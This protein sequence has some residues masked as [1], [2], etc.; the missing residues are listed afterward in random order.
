MQ[1]PEGFEHLHRAG[2]NGDVDQAVFKTVAARQEPPRSQH[3]P[4]EDGG[5]QKLI[6]AGDAFANAQPCQAHNECKQPDERERKKEKTEHYSFSS[7]KTLTSTR[8]FFLF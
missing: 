5:D 7:G 2:Q 1:R 3:Q 6:P 8:R 4:D